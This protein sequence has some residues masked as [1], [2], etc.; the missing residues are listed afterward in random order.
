MEIMWIV[1][2]IIAVF[3]LGFLIFKFV[4]KAAFNNELR[5]VFY[6][7]KKLTPEEFFKLKRKTSDFGG[8]SKYDESGV[9][10]IFNKSSSMY[11]VGQSIHLI[12]RVN[13]H[14][15]GKGN[16][17]VYADYK[18][19]ADFEITL[20]PCPREDLNKVERHYIEIFNA[21]GKGYNKNKGKKKKK[22]LVN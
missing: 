10:V 9:Y 2:A 3:I 14:F 6:E 19:G 13:D 20:I 12:K 16:G 18:Y 15:T 21:Y 17:D 11:Y 7:S 22:I 4:R 1:F 8:R 5:E